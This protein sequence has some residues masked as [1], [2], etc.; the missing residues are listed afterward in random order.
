[1]SLFYP[2]SQIP[3]LSPTHR[4]IKSPTVLVSDASKFIVLLR[5]YYTNFHETL[6]FLSLW[7][8][9]DTCP[10][11][12]SRG[13]QVKVFRSCWCIPELTNKGSGESLFCSFC[14]KA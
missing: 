2:S 9:F 4:Y 8:F 6:K 1:M 7:I 3:R 5:L 12:F 14:E 10:W 11:F 13:Y